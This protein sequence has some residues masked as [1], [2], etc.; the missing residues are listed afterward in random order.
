MREGWEGGVWRQYVHQLSK[1]R[2]AFLFYFDRRHSFSA[3]RGIPALTF[4]FWS[5]VFALTFSNKLF[6]ARSTGY[7]LCARI[8]GDL[9]LNE[10]VFFGIIFSGLI[11]CELFDTIKHLVCSGSFYRT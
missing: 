11:C 2:R 9:F 4:R 5:L 3:F 10:T 8:F 7:L 6:E 1:E